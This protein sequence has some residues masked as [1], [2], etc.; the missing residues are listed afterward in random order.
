MQGSKNNDTTT[1]SL[2]YP[3]LGEPSQHYPYSSPNIYQGQNLSNLG[4]RQNFQLSNSP[5]ITGAIVGSFLSK[6]GLVATLSFQ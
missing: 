5:A 6:V 1:S 4:F 2:S 3:E